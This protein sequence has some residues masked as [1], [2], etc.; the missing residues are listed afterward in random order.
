MSWSKSS[1]YSTLRSS[2]LHDSPVDRRLDFCR[3]L[4]KVAYLS[5]IGWSQAE[6]TGHVGVWR[7]C[8]NSSETGRFDLS[9]PLAFEIA[10]VFGKNVAEVFLR[11]RRCVRES[12]Q[13]PRTSR[14]K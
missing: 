9:L 2:G 3:L 8:M 14:G 5:A 12:K 11:Q 4:A 6:P 1:S 13:F 10:R 7:A